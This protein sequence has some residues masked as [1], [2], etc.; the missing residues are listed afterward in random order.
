MAKREATNAGEVQ[1]VLLMPLGR[2]RVGKTVI[3]NTVAQFFKKAGA[4]LQVWD[5]DQQTTSHGL[6]VFHPEA[7]VPPHAGLADLAKWLEGKIHE[8]ALAKRAG[9]PFDALLGVGGG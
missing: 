7:A 9:R 5:M 2:G 6:A 4:T 8:Q 3:G 1:P